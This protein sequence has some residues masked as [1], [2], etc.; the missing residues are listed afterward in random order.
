ME[1]KIHVYDYRCLAM[2][3]A[4][5]RIEPRRWRLNPHPLA[6]MWSAL[7]DP[8]VQWP[9]HSLA[10]HFRTDELHNYLTGART[11]FSAGGAMRKLLSRRNLRWGTRFQLCTPCF[12]RGPHTS[13]RNA[14]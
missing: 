12:R 11:G 14:G 3:L 6:G 4:R 8:N 2:S 9:R 13:N 10:K 5:R 7:P 1:R